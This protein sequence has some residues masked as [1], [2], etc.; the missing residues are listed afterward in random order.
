[1]KRYRVSPIP[2]HMHPKIHKERRKARADY[3]RV[4]MEGRENV[5]YTDAA[6]YR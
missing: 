5:M 4:K 6:A 3:Y 1:M 2:R